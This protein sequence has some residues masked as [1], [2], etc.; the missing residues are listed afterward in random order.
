M[1][2]I[3]L[4][5]SALGLRPAVLR[6]ADAL[7]ELGHE[8]TAPDYYDGQVFDEN[9]AGLAYRDR[10]GSGVLFKQRLLP[11]LADLPD[12]AVL[13]GF[14]LGS[15]FAQALAARRPAARAVILMHSVAAPRGAWP[16]QP[17]QLHRYAN[18]P[19]VDPADAQ[20]LGQAVRDSGASFDDFV[21][22]GSGHLFTD[23]DGPDGDE[24]ATR[25]TVRR[26]GTL[27]AA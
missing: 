20:A 21:T 8:V 17:V 14:S 18:D 10:V 15:A 9:A 16:G 19:F 7:R 1:S 22:L 13:A 25:L 12:D 6:F 4:L 3:L 2:H 23:T 11:M 5:H 26:I 24:E 27:L